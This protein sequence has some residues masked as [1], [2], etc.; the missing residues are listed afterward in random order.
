[1]GALGS[2]MQ[3]ERKERE[4]RARAQRASAQRAYE[5]QKRREA[6]KEGRVGRGLRATGIEFV[7]NQQSTASSWNRRTGC[8]EY[9][10]SASQIEAA[11]SRA[12]RIL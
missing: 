12:L 11:S 8:W 10:N 5:E 4:K 1:M 6:G 7:A 2:V 9:K 3:K